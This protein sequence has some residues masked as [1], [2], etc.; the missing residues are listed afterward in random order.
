MLL[1]VENV[2]FGGLRVTILDE[3]FFNYVL[4]FLDCRATVLAETILELSHNLVAD[5]LGLF[6]VFA[7]YSFGGFPNSDCYAFLIERF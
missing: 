3:H 4:D 7:A 1:P 2:G 5:A 6:T